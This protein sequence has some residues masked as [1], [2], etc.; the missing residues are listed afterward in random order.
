MADKKVKKAK[1]KKSKAIKVEK[2]TAGKM[3][4]GKPKKAAAKK[5]PVSIEAI[6][7]LHVSRGI[8]PGIPCICIENEEGWF[9]M[10]EMRNGELKGCDGPFETMEECERHTCRK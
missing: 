10:K 7:Q 1:S 3:N 6:P 9:C 8:R 2:N 5:K 4:K